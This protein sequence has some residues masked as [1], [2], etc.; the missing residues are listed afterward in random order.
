MVFACMEDMLTEPPVFR[1][2]A[3]GIWREGVT[4]VE[5]TVIVGVDIVLVIRVDV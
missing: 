2:V 5:R 3:F 1:M 4:M